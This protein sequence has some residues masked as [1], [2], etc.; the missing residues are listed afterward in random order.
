VKF[1]EFRTGVFA[2][3]K[4]CIRVGLRPPGLPDNWDECSSLQQA[5]ILGFDQVCEHD[6][7]REKATFAGVELK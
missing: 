4:A 6:D 1:P 3:W 5:L 7:F 2:I